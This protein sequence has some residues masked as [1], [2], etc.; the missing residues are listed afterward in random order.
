[1]SGT[2]NVVG[3]GAD[4]TAIA[5]DRNNKQAILKIVHRLQTS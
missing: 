1:M 5:A 4:A 2:V 3:A